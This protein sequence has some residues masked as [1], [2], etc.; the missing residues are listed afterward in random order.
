MLGL[1]YLLHWIAADGDGEGLQTLKGCWE[2]EGL[3]DIKRV[4]AKIWTSINLAE[5]VSTKFEDAQ[6]LQDNVLFVILLV[7][8]RQGFKEQQKKQGGGRGA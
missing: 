5:K 1:F 7:Y 4:A 6:I 2:G 8:Q 3:P